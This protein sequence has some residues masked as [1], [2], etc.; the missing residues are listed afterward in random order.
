MHSGHV[1]AAEA[2]FEAQPARDRP[3]RA[4]GT[5]RVLVVGDS[6]TW[7]YAIVEEEAFPQVAERVFA[8]RG[9]PDIEVINGGVPDYNS[10]Q[11]RALIQ[12]LL[13]IYQPD[14]VVLAYVVNDAEPNLGPSSP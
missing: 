11:E 8:E 14:A 9:R 10:R 7:G 4:P 12:K 3:A 1:H 5:K 2:I 13:P 6:Y